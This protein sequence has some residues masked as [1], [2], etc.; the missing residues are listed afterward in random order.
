MSS[1]SFRDSY[2]P[3]ALVTGAAQ[4]IG[5][6]FAEG[7][8][9]RGLNL[10]LLDL[11]CEA[12]TR[13]AREIETGHAVEARPLIAD[14]SD[15]GFIDLVEGAVAQTQVGLLV[16]NA[17]FGRTGPFLDET[18]E[19][20]LRAVDVNCAATVALTH[21]LAPRMVDRG[22]GGILLVASG[23]ALHGSPGHANYA[24]TKAFDLVLGESLWDEFREH[25]VDVLAFVPGPTNTPG[26]RSFVPG[27]REG[28][29]VGRI[30]LPGATAEIALE[31]LGKGPSAASSGLS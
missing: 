13:A 10:H 24:A 18:L 30:Q 11:E 4:G 3:W 12:V 23:T 6:A 19:E 29:A 16:C 7:L 27:L 22:R 15:R 21:L 28:M 9:R 26:L 20:L 5:R 14:L 31:A 17:A 1:T 25:G 2:G 8:A